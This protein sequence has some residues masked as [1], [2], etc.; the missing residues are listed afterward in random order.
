M[1]VYDTEEGMMEEH[2]YTLTRQ[3]LLSTAMTLFNSFGWRPILPARSSSL[4]LKE[5]QT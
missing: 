5:I 2:T 4:R 1:S 3:S